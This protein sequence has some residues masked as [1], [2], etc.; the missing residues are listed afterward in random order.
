M[1]KEIKYEEFLQKASTLA[2]EWESVVKDL[3]KRSGGPEYP[4]Y[5][6]GKPAIPPEGVQNI[7]VISAMR[8]LYQHYA[9]LPP[10]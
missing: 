4:K 10:E 9:V 5:P 2:R 7:R 6:D 3:N 1:L 8:V